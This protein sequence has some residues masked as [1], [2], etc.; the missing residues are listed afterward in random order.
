MVGGLNTSQTDMSDRVLI[1]GGSGMLGHKLSQVVSQKA[2][3]YVTMRHPELALEFPHVFGKT[4]IVEGVDA[5]DVESIERAFL[6]AK[7][8][9][10]V[11]AIGIV[12]QIASSRDAVNSISVNS[13]FPHR[14][15]ECCARAGARLISISTDCVFSGERGN[16]SESDR[17]D[18]E[19][20]YGRTKLL[21]EVGGPNCL[22]IRTSII[23]PQIQGE[24]SLL[25]WFLRQKGG[26]IKG[27]RKA[28]FTGWPTVELAEIITQVIACH[29]ELDGVFH[30][31][32]EPISKFELLSL[33]N[34]AYKLDVEI[35]PDDVFDC[36][37]SL[38]SERFKAQTGIVAKPWKELVRKMHE[39]SALY[40]VPACR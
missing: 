17:P 1:F 15:A 38:N 40:T 30:V 6:V 4:Q 11:N 10:V 19:D 36:N 35:V 29:R 3:T 28:I 2:E 26:T 7:P 39:D 27:Y 25:E 37:R 31:S 12:K 8:A 9:V 32:T 20:Q 34:E 22:T 18:P 5:Q 33:I 16:Y 24:Y 21:G 14:L 23:G 13:V